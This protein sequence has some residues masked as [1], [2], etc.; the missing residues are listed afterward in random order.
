MDRKALLPLLLSTLL[1]AGCAGGSGGGASPQAED[2]QAD[3]KENVLTASQLSSEPR[4]LTEEEILTAYDRAVEAYGWFERTPLPDD[5]GEAVQVDGKSYRRVDS[6]GMGDLEDLRTYLRSLF[7]VDLTAS[8]L[9]G[10]LY[11]DVDGAL[12]VTSLDRSGGD[13]L[14]GGVDV[15]VSQ[16]ASDRYRVDVAVDILAEDLT[17][18]GREFWSFP[19]DFVDGRWVFTDFQLVF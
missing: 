9:S 16:A 8:L 13:A 12:Y 19:Y 11:R 2:I 14:R 1:L 3:G 4:P 17:V 5:G 15:Q 10:G 6:P 7:S 18:A